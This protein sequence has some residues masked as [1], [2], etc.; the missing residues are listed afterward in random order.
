M[1]SHTWIPTS[2]KHSTV[3]VAVSIIE[4]RAVWHPSSIQKWRGV[5]SLLL[6]ANLPLQMLAVFATIH[7]I[8]EGR[9]K[10]GRKRGPGYQK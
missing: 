9:F 4:E 6:R 1:D 3:A 2:V 8:Q 10:D 7:G 5:N